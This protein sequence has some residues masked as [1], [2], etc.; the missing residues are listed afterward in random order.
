MGIGGFL[1]DL[2]S[3]PVKLVSVP[4]KLGEEL[5]DNVLD[6][7]VEGTFSKPIRNAGDE[8]EEIFDE[9]DE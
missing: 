3:T 6:L 8:I 5:L 9:I 7:D 4:V 1:G 2:I